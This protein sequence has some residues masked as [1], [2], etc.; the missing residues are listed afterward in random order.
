MV[1]KKIGFIGFGEAAYLISSGLITEKSQEIIA[2][3]VN[4]DHPSLGGKLRK[5][6]E[7]L[8]VSLMPTLQE[9]IQN[10]Q[11]IISATSA[12]YA[13][14]V[15]KD[16][17]PYLTND[18][19][20]VDINA[21]SP[22][23]KEEISSIM[24]D[25]AK[26]VDVAVVESIPKY[27]HKVPLLI[28]GEGAKDFESYANEVEMDITFID[29]KPGS[30]S[31]IKMIRSVF[32]KG[33]TMLMIET[34]IASNKYGINEWIM[35]SI[36]NSLLDKPFAETVNLLITR[37]AEHSERRVSEMEEVIKTL[38]ALNVNSLLSQATKDKLS[39]FVEMNLKDEFLDNSPRDFIDVIEKIDTLDKSVI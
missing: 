9:L 31:A 30:A 25:K 24:V 15:A 23:V 3:D 7:E 34:L 37:T 29:D 11:I 8:G 35:E 14:S 12:K 38:K 6:A 33:F 19:L 20:F 28:S 4:Q 27:K 21:A 39:Q 16:A 2:Y 1:S 32:M 5:R 18:Q 10:S 36:E 13:L 22:M 17:L 26:F